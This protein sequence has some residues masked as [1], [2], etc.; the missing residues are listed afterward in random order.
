MLEFKMLL[1]MAFFYNRFNHL[2]AQY[3]V[4]I[5]PGIIAYGSRHTKLGQ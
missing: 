3:I 2:H 1:S 5:T 4:L